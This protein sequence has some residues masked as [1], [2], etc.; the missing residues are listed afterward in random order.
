MIVRVLIVIVLVASLIISVGCD[1]DENIVDSPKPQATTGLLKGVSVSPR[2]FDRHFG[3]FLDKVKETQDVL[4]WAGDWMEVHDKKAPTTF[5]E[6]ASK[7]EYIPIIE[8][9]HY[10]QESGDLFR[11]LNEENKQIYMD[12]TIEFVKEHEPPYFGMG[13][14]TDIFAKK[15]PAA[16]E[17]FVLFY[18]D[19]YDAVKLV[20]PNTKVFTVF[21]L[22]TMKGL[23]MWEIEE[24]V[25]HWD[26]IDRFKTDIVAFTTYPGLFYRNPSDVPLDHYT[27][28]LSHT[29]KPI[30]FTEIGW[31]SAPSP[32][33]WES[34]EAEQV[35]FIEAFFN[36]TDELNME[37]A[38]WSFMYVAYDGE[39]FESMGLHRSDGT[40]KPAWNAWNEAGN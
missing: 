40:A 8:V 3:E 12:S 17:E 39:P 35:E 22:E 7:Y 5:S 4:V 2:S 31:H 25:P 14:E 16:F 27:E 34:S 26:M 1:D 19:V 6:L 28:I 24:N 37:V 38:V 20:S 15:N 23:T 18:N 10:I 21:Q 33:G 9:G 29:S 13:V 11:P 32:A 36:L 30:A